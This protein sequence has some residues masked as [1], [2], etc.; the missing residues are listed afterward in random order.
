MFWLFEVI[1][2]YV[3]ILDSIRFLKST[4]HF[5]LETEEGLTIG[6]SSFFEKST[7]P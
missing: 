2:L 3:W 7:W 6:T 5:F 1:F 4:V